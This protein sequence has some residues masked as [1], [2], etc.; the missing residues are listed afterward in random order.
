MRSWK[1]ELFSRPALVI[2]DMQNAFFETPALAQQRGAVTEQCSMLLNEARKHDLLIVNVCTIHQRDKSTWTL[3]MLED[4]QGF[5]FEGTEQAR[6][7]NE[8]DLSRS[9]QVIKHR[10]SAFWQ[11]GLDGL[12]HFHR[13]RALILAGVASDSC[14]AATAADAFAANYRVAV[15][16]AAVASGDPDF[17]KTTLQQMETLH[18]QPAVDTE[19]LIKAMSQGNRT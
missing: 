2:I 11:T 4:D 6:N 9:V 18:R 14:V 15:A 16:K 10:D 19:S 12:L 5:L 17:E 8:L 7:L 3:S 13:I 1:P